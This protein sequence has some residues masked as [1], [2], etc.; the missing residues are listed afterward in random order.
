MRVKPLNGC[1]IRNISKSP[2]S[3]PNVI[4]E[5]MDTLNMNQ[6]SESVDRLKKVARAMTTC[7][8][9]HLVSIPLLLCP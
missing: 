9:E 6:R 8:S 5:S 1:A 2:S 7:S 4:I 3:V